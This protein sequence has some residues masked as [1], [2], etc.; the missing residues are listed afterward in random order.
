M[1]IDDILIENKFGQNINENV[2]NQIHIRYE[3]G[4]IIL[5]CTEIQ[6]KA[7]VTVYNI[8]GE[9]VLKTT[10]SNTR[11][12]RIGFTAI[13]GTYIIHFVGDNINVSKK[14]VITY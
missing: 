4:A 12:E 2:Q 5:D 14:L 7:D 1:L 3:Q 11:T 9:Q 10:L 8:L 6:Q 13:P